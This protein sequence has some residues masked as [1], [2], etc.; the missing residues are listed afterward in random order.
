MVFGSKKRQS[1]GMNLGRGVWIPLPPHSIRFWN[2]RIL[3][4]PLQMSN[5]GF[6]GTRNFLNLT[7][8]VANEVTTALFRRWTK[9]CLKEWESRECVDIKKL[10][11]FRAYFLY[12]I[13]NNHQHKVLKDINDRKVHNESFKADTMKRILA[14]RHEL[15]FPEAAPKTFKRGLESKWQN[16]K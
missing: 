16:S 3:T 7:L 5:R 10:F 15:A 14:S 12:S 9:N 6:V 1:G 13:S 2:F 4:R 8:A 11:H